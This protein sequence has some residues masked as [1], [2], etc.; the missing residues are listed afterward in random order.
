VTFISDDLLVKNIS[1]IFWPI[2]LGLV[3][4]VVSGKDSHHSFFGTAIKGIL[5]GAFLYAVLYS[6]TTN[7]V[8]SKIVSAI[9]VGVS[10]FLI[11]YFL[12]NDFWS[13]LP[14]SVG[15]CVGG[16][17]WFLRQEIQQKLRMRGPS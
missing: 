3:V 15:V 10:F 9:L 12:T 8:L 11:S 17:L 13:L 2:F 4:F 14:I 1:K 7:T 16:L 6:I 5:C